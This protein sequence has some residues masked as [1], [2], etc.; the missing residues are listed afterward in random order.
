MALLDA[1]HWATEWPWLPVA[2][3]RLARGTGLA[4]RVHFWTRGDQH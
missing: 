2:A 4:T 1:A 3:A